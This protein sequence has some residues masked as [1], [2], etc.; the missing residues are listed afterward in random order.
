M[1]TAD[2]MGDPDA[3]KDWRQEKGVTEDEMV[4]WHHWL[5]GHEL[6][7]DLG[8]RWKTGKPGVLRS[9][10]SQRVR[11]DW[12]TEQW[13]SVFSLEG[14]HR[15]RLFFPQQGAAADWSGGGS[16][17]PK[18]PSCLKIFTTSLGQ[19]LPFLPKIQSSVADESL[20]RFLFLNIGSLLLLQGECRL[21]LHIICLTARQVFNSRLEKVWSKT[22]VG[23]WVRNMIFI[24]KKK[25]NF[26]LNYISLF[27][28]NGSAAACGI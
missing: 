27:D 7:T 8:R 18:L 12:A 26:F 23:S 13:S 14:S 6:W 28:C 1:R 9:M 11:H 24:K 21:G 4:G 25:K 17:M 19:V 20:A 22:T 16:T 15:Q 10:G 3:G 5:N 2:S